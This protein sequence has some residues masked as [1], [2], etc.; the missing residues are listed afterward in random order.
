[1][2]YNYEINDFSEEWKEL[3]NS[4]EEF[5]EKKSNSIRVSDIFNYGLKVFLHLPTTEV[6]SL[7]MLSSNE[8]LFE[9]KYSIP[10]GNDSQSIKLFDYLIENGDVG[11]AINNSSLYHTTVDKEFS[12]KQNLL[13]IPL[14]VSTGIIGVLVIQHSCNFEDIK[15]ITFKLISLFFEF[16]CRYFRK[17][18]DIKG[19]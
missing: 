5:I 1:M 11:S 13:I 2:N 7:F 9:H 14:K 16:I 10:N 15:Q 12:I 3:L 17:C 6:V 19:Y 4:M 8:F 18:S